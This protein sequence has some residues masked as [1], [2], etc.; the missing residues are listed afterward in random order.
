FGKPGRAYAYGF[1]SDV[2]SRTWAELILAVGEQ[3]GA[4]PRRSIRVDETRFRPGNT[5]IRRLGVDYAAFTAQTGWRPQY[6]REAGVAA[7][8]DYYRA[9]PDRWKSLRDW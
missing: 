5:E 2:S 4:W 9:H 7:T 6:S 3:Q 1:G 8:I